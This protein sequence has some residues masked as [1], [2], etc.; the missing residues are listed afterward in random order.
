MVQSLWKRVWR[1]LKK[2]KIELPFDTVI[3]LLGIYAEKTMTRYN[4]CTPMFTEALYTVAKTTSNL[5]VHDRGVDKE[6]VLHIDN[7]ILLSH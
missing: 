4:P 1:F 5:N 7:G 3:P 2:L 6:E